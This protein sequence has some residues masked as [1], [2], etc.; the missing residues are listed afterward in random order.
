MF[1]GIFAVAAAG[2]WL[3]AFAVFQY[4]TSFPAGSG[5]KISVP[6]MLAYLIG[7]FAIGCTEQT[8]ANLWKAVKV[9]RGGAH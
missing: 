7:A 1:A 2:L 6:A 3:G 8:I 9:R 4:A 5:P